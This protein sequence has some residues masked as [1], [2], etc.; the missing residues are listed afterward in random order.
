ESLYVRTLEARRR[1]LSPIHHSAFDTMMNLV[2][3]YEEQGRYVEA[4]AELLGE[5]EQFTSA[6]GAEHKG[7][8]AIAA[9]LAKLYEAWDK[10]EQAAVYRALP[11]P[12]EAASADGEAP[13]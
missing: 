11:P 12:A 6:L 7:S 4:E 13:E 10:P 2:S 5:Y 1:A 3:L 8:L 9:K